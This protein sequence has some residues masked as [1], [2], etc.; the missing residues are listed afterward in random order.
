VNTTYTATY[1]VACPPNVTSQLAIG[2]LGTSRLGT[3]SY[4]LQW[5]TVQNKTTSTIPGP[6]V[7][8]I[9]NLQGASVVAPA[10]TTSCGPAAVNPGVT[11]QATG[12][13]LTPGQAA[14]VPV[15]YQKVGTLPV[16]GVPNVLSG[17]PR[18]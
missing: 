3:S 17:I 18:R 13:Q 12:N 4:Y 9:G 5:L 1:R 14:L 16:T 11:I 2:N 6:Q 10:L 15:L 7:L 8:V